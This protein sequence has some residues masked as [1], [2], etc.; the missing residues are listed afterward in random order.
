[1]SLSNREIKFRFYCE[2]SD[3][4]SKA[5]TIEELA[6]SMYDWHSDI[7]KIVKNQ[8]TGLK[9]KNGVEIYEGDIVKFIPS[10]EYGKV[11]TFGKSQNLGIEWENSKTAFFTPMFYLG[12]ESE[13]EIIGNIYENPELLKG[14]VSVNKFNIYQYDEFTPPFKIASFDNLNAAKEELEKIQDNS[15]KHDAYTCFCIKE[16]ANEPIKNS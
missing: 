16:E 8:Y 4:L 5:F 14:E 13:L 12:C 3:T 15:I 9:D 7:H 1:M 10:G 11:T 2:D 6:N